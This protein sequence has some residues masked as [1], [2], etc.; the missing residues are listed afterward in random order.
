MANP[1]K[2]QDYAGEGSVLATSTWPERLRILNAKLTRKDL[3]IV[4]VDGSPVIRRKPEAVIAQR[5]F[6]ERRERD[7]RIRNQQEA[8]DERS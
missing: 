5:Q 4:L 8:R 3:E 7:L 1:L 2:K 6:E